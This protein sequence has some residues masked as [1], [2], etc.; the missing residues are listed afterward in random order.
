MKG[1]KRYTPWYTLHGTTSFTIWR[2]MLNTDIRYGLDCFALF[3]EGRTWSTCALA[4]GAY[5]LLLCQ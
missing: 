3:F 1:A 4:E 5:C 2:T